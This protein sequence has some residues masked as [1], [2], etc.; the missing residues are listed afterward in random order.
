MCN[1]WNYSGTHLLAFDSLLHIVVVDLA[2]YAMQLDDMKKSGGLPFLSVDSSFSMLDPFETIRS[3]FSRRRLIRVFR[4]SII[5]WIYPL[6]TPILYFLLF[7]IA[8]WV[9]LFAPVAL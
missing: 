7:V 9:L 1:E 5:S 4:E 3:L 8:T 6:V 2:M